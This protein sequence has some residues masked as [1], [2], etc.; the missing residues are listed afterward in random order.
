MGEELFKIVMLAI[1]LPA[2][3]VVSTPFIFALALLEPSRYLESV[4]ERYVKVFAAWFH[5]ASHA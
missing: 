4:R 3:V 1:L 2:I 5:I